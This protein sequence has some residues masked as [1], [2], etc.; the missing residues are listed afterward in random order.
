VDKRIAVAEKSLSSLERFAKERRRASEEGWADRFEA[1][2]ASD[3]LSKGRLD[4]LDLERERADL[5]VA[6]ELASGLYLPSRPPSG[7]EGGG[8]KEKKGNKGRTP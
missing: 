8:R 4:L 1:F 5:S 7:E 6:L 2:G 3:E